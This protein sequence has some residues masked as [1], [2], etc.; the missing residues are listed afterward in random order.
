MRKIDLNAEAIFE[1]RK[2]AGENIRSGQ[3]KFYWATALP[4]ADHLKLTLA[5]IES[6]KVLEIGCASGYDA[7]IYATKAKEYIGV[8]ISDVAISNCKALHIPNGTFYCVD[9]HK[10]PIDDHSIDVVIVNSLLHHLDLVIAF[11]EIRRVLTSEGMLIFREPLGTNFMFQIYRSLTPGARTVDERPFT[12]KDLRLMRSYFVFD[13]VQWFGF[14]NIMSAY[15]RI[16]V[17]RRLLT[18]LDRWLSRTPLKFFYWQFAGIAKL[19]K[20]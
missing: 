6:K 14:S 4:V 15:F 16:E 8:D 2:A 7:K 17:V 11:N 1:N 13:D 5:K 20:Y 9:G 12:L 10:L 18:V 19:R 3:D